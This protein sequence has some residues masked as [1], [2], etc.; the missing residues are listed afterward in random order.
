VT[1]PSLAIAIAF[2]GRAP[3]WLPAFL[4]S[5]R[6]NTDVQ[7]FL[8]SDFEPPAPFPPNVTLRRMPLRE[9]SE[10]ASEALA[11]RIEV[12]PN[13]TKKIIDLKPAFGLIFA[14]DLRPF[15]FWAHS[16]L[17]I[18]WGD[19]RHFVT[20]ALLAQ[21]DMVSSRPGRTSGHFNLFRNTPAMNRTFELI[22]DVRAAMA[23]PEYLHLDERE[24]TRHL[25]QHLHEAADRAPRVHW[26]ENLTTDAKC[27][28]ALADGQSLWWRNGKTF[29]A[30]GH[31]FMYLHFHKI[32][33]DAMTI[34]FG[35]EDRPAAF[36]VD[37]RGFLA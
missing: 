36:S 7:W 4:L 3:M 10:R 24:L 5:C 12:Q 1:H 26:P 35:F 15:D 18:V 2:F 21:H 23:N 30:D 33:N 32:K 19:V 25:K 27:Q 6:P 37:R 29:G 11:T 8:Y 17:D 14:D 16:D 34:N 28:R 9:F 20:D 22:P 13:F 31:E